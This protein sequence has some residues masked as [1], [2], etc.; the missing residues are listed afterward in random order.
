MKDT[1]FNL[2][3][4][5]EIME[6][7]VDKGKLSSSR[8]KNMQHDNYGFPTKRDDL[9]ESD[10]HLKPGFKSQNKSIHSW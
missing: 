3:A 6:T 7:S 4:S 5:R 1:I 8:S 9:D 2:S 10:K